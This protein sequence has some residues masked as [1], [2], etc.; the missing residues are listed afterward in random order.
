MSTSQSAELPVSG[1]APALKRNAVGL[2]AVIFQSVTLT[3]PAGACATAL[4]I[5]TSY[6]GGS[7]PLAILL[8][9]VACV[10]LSVSIAEL[11]IHL[12]SAGGFAT[13]VSRSLGPSLG[14]LTSWGMLIGYAT[15]P[16]FYFGFF[17]LVIKTEFDDNVFSSP[18]WF[19][20]PFAGLIAAVVGVLAYRGIELSTRAGIVLGVLEIAVLV[21]LALTLIVHA[22]ASNTATG[23]TPHSANKHGWGS[24]IPA[25]LYG[26]LALIGFESAVPIAEEAKNPRRTIGR[27]IVIATLALGALFI[28]VYYA[29]GAF[30]GASQ[31]L[32]FASLNGGDPLTLLGNRVWDGLGFIIVLAVLNSLIASCNAASNAF[33]RMTFSMARARLLPSA[34]ARLHPRFRTPHVT[35]ALLISVSIVVSIAGGLAVGPLDLL[36]ALATTLTVIFVAIYILVAISSGVFYW[37]NSRSE[38]NLVKHVLI[39]LVA[40]GFFVLVEIA[41]FGINFAGLG[42]A[43]VEGPAKIG[44]WIAAGAMAAGV[45]AVAV[46]AKRRPDDLARLDDVFLD[47]TSAQDTRTGVQQRVPGAE[48][49][50]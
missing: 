26:V 8:A 1:S 19:W 16:M 15:V 4:L 37:R 13:Y 3:A 30:L 50:T 27:A 2:G 32:G 48:A 46:I 24:V 45:A 33:T 11:A 17:G 43:P 6:A 25:A 42:I 38:F 36:V 9:V 35:T 18:S 34:G 39:P 47:E 29:I 49:A 10:F 28:F 12:P 5:V 40:V 7:T 22:G 44:L 20:V 23:F 14:F 31:M 21:A 41:S